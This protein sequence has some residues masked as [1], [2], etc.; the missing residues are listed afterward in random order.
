MYFVF[1]LR[2]RISISCVSTSVPHISYLGFFWLACPCLV[3]RLRSRI[4]YILIIWLAYVYLVF[5]LR[6]RI[7]ISCVSTS[8][9]HI[10]YLGFFWLACPCLVF[11]LRSRISYILIIWLAYV[12][13]VFRLR[14]RISI[15]CVS[16]SVPHISYLGLWRMVFLLCM[17]KRARARMKWGNCSGKHVKKRTKRTAWSQRRRI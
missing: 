2:P 12:Y 11:R 9:P 4:S 5:R 7:S 13:L 14:P 15:L 10:S 17:Q 1:R 3:F 8:V 6:P 16:T